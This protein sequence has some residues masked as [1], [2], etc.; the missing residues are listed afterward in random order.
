MPRLAPPEGRYFWQAVLA[1]LNAVELGSRSEE[2]PLLPLMAIPP[3]E[4]LGSGKSGTPCSRMHCA[5]RSAACFGSVEGLF[6]EAPVPGHGSEHPASAV[7]GISQAPANG[8]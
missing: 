8:G 6:E 2:E 7:L 1:S 5:K 3:F 4:V